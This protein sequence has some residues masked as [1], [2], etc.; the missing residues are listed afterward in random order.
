MAV[1]AKNTLKK[2]ELVYNLRSDA[3]GYFLFYHLRIHY[4][5]LLY[6]HNMGTLLDIIYGVANAGFF[7]YPGAFVRWIFLRPKRSFDS[8]LKEDPYIN[9]GFT[10][11]IIAVA[12]IALV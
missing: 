2:I 3:A 4:L 11:L 8:L 1:P 6:R 12:V 5:Y 10:L 9:S 7:Q